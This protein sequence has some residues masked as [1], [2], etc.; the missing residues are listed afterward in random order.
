MR[1]FLALV[2]FFIGGAIPAVAASYDSEAA[3]GLTLFQDKN[4]SIDR[5]VACAS[6]HDPHKYFADG[7]RVSVG[8]SRRLGTR[9][10]P[11]LTRL[12]VYTSFFWDGRA[13][14]LEQ[15]IA[16]P[17]FSPMEM[18]LA[19]ES[20]LVKRLQES[21]AYLDAFKRLYGTPPDAVRS[22]DA[23]RAIV[24]YE[25]SLGTQPSALTRYLSGDLGALSQAARAGLEIFRGKAACSRC[26]HVGPGAPT[27]TD[28]SFHPSSVG[29]GA[30]GTRLAQVVKQMTTWPVSQRV[31]C[32]Q[33]D[34]VCAALGRY[35]LT[36]EPQDIG[37]VR[38]PSLY[39][40]SHTSPYMHDGSIAT[41]PQAVDEELYYQ[42][43]DR[44]SPIILSGEERQFLL[45]F[46]KEI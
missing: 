9:N 5:T 25:R 30:V 44:G 28:N 22:A 3:L 19:D 2:I 32:V 35:A 8:A 13:T 45:Q 23:E 27:F 16:G 41:L 20:G 17:L 11:S 6:C 7:R 4:L 12:D 36:L 38:T 1:G 15:Q 37:K 26:H 31:R 42:G 10:A 34:I 14:T 18:G 24:A 40:V 39:N 46:L 21:S 29:F 43:V 33:T